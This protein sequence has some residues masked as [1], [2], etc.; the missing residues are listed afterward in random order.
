MNTYHDRLLYW[1]LRFVSRCKSHNVLTVI[2]DSMDKSKL[3]YPQFAFGRR[4][5][6]LDSFI[7]PKLVITAAIAHGYG[8]EFHI[9]QDELETHWMCLA[10]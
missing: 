8:A 10:L 9:A 1:N 5:K 4:P 3:V 6:Q 7:R 2:V